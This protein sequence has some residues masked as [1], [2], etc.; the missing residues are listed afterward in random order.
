MT[1][2]TQSV[3]NWY[4]TAANGQFTTDSRSA[5]RQQPPHHGHL[6]QSSYPIFFILVQPWVTLGIT[7]KEAKIYTG[8]WE[9]FTWPAA[10]LALPAG[11]GG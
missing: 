9:S 3:A 10:D 5:M 1:G 7:A 6:F 2:Q 11:E 8:L 4:S